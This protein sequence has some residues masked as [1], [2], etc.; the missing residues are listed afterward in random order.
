[1]KELN[2]IIKMFEGKDLTPQQKK[3]LVSLNNI[4][5]LLVN[6]DL[7]IIELEREFERYCKNSCTAIAE[8]EDLRS[9][10][11]RIKLERNVKKV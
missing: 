11:V 3:I 4:K 8:V 6:K 7:H 2:D 1:M 10:L 5:K 9:K